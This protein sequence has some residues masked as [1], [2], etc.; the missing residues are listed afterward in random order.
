MRIF[1][2]IVHLVIALLV[3]PT[4]TLAQA[5]YG[6]FKGDVVA[7]FLRDGR[8]MQL[9]KSFGFIDVRG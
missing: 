1:V 8:N 7:K 5:S 4:V 6:Q 9:E 3:L 2:P